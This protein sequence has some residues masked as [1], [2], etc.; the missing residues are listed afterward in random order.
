MSIKKKILFILLISV[1]GYLA[2]HFSLVRYGFRQLV[3]QLSLINSSIPVDEA[4]SQVSKVEGDKIQLIQQV[5]A[6]AQN[7]LYLSVD[8]SSYSSFVKQDSNKTMWVVTAAEPYMLE[9]YNWNYGPLGGMP[10]KGFFDY[11]L[12]KAEEEKIRNQGFDTDLGTASG[13]S[14]LGILS[15]PIL[16]NMLERDSAQ[17]VELIIHELTHATIYNFGETTWNENMATF[18]GREGTKRFITDQ[19]NDSGLLSD[20]E[21]ALKQKELRSQFIYQKANELNVLYQS[22]AFQTQTNEEKQK[23]KETF[24]HEFMNSYLIRF[25]NKEIDAEKL[26]NNTL[27][28]DFLMYHSSLDSLSLVLE[29]QF[30][31]NLP[32]F[33]E[34]HK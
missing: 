10:Y 26:P 11:R 17:L 20:Y 15:E 22:E 1:V 19:L 18:I 14:T 7:H 2:C 13:W 24:M 30:Q 8:E 29:N 28:T 21:S 32:E 23:V 9:D 33:I 12:A 3:G 4:I 31:G 34:A 25:P 16:S 27:F 6:Y 5:K